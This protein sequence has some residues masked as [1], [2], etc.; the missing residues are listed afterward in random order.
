MSSSEKH[1]DG[2]G[3]CLSTGRKK[4]GSRGCL[5]IVALLIVGFAYFGVQIWCYDPDRVLSVRA[6]EGRDATRF[7]LYDHR[8]V[9]LIGVGFPPAETRGIAR[10][11]VQQLIEGKH[12]R[13]ETD[14]EEISAEKHLLSYVYVKVR[15][16]QTALDNLLR[17]LKLPTGKVH[18]N[19]D[20]E[21][22][23]NELLIRLG[24]CASAPKPPNLKYRT[25]FE[26]VQSEARQEFLGMW[27]KDSE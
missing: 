6:E 22:F 19:A 10:D 26:H 24:L 4:S 25:A 1:A 23:I 27:R 21:V 11:V 18:L 8:M 14:T 20:G 17:R 15:G 2:G 7:E 13:I 5:I 9:G 16:G 3:P 12:I